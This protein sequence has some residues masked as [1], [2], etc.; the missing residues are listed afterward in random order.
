MKPRIFEAGSDAG[1]TWGEEGCEIVE[2]LGVPL[3]SCEA[4]HWAH[5][6]REGPQ[7]LPR[8]QP[9]HF[10]HIFHIVEETHK[11]EAGVRTGCKHC[12]GREGRFRS[13]FQL[14]LKLD[15]PA[16]MMAAAA[17]AYRWR[18]CHAEGWALSSCL[19]PEK[20]SRCWWG[21]NAGRPGWSW[22]WT[23]CPR[24]W[25]IRT[26]RQSCRWASPMAKVLNMQAFYWCVKEIME[27]EIVSLTAAK[28]PKLPINCHKK[29]TNLHM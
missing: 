25:H 14:L 21:D 27:G 11:Q 3:P 5:F 4:H 12:R 19:D 15:A 9:V 13:G 23:A 6:Q 16:E 22:T 20:R 1:C 28:F 8:A 17:G 18:P 26:Q 7:L 10:Q 2:D 24:W 29:D